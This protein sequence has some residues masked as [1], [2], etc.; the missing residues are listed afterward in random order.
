MPELV[1]YKLSTGLSLLALPL[2]MLAERRY[3]RLQ[4]LPDSDI[5]GN[6]PSLSII[7]PARNEAF[8]LP[9][10]LSSL[11]G[12]TYPG[13]LEILVVDDHS[14]DQTA[15]VA[16]A[17]DAAL[18]PLTGGIPPGWLG[19]PF[20]CH[21]GAFLAHGEWLLFT[22]ADTVHT[23]YGAA[24]AVSFA[25]QNNLDGL[26]LFISQQS[27]HWCDRLA[28]SAAHAGLFAGQHPSNHLL[29]G[30]FILLRRQVYVESG[31]F[32]AVSNEPLEDVAL[33][34]HLYQ[35]GFHVP[36]MSGADIA[37][38][39]MY[40]NR[41]QMFFGM[42]RL[43]SAALRWE[44]S[45]AAI[46]VLLITALMSPLIVLQ[47]VLRGKFHWRWLPVSWI[48]ASLSL[49]PWT[50]R[51]GNPAWALLAPIGALVVQVAGVYGILCRLLGR[52]IP[53]KDRQV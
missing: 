36:V 35:Q 23:Q 37:Q 13:E 44:R 39:R 12:Q 25:L 19:K 27:D 24:R 51:F 2:G 14:T 20:A 41:K 53:W 7:I 42:S 32:A 34:N 10:L 47:G 26:S 28:L 43:A 52:G 46:T 40:S 48:A 15:I 16:R 21:Q 3:R 29:N 50:R 9:G 17:Y 33:G 30:Q 6:L 8:N 22:D 49:L 18:L 1:N 5:V 38:V 11:N 45:W 4:S 31:G